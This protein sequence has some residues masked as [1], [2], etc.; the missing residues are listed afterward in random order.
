MK[1]ITMGLYSNL[2]G[3]YLMAGIFPKRAVLSTPKTQV[4]FQTAKRERFKPVLSTLPLQQVPGAPNGSYKTL[5]GAGL[6]NP[7]APYRSNWP[8]AEDLAYDTEYMKTVIESQ[9]VRIL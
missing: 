2:K 1:L 3:F 4:P 7:A 5:L 8:S 6:N 9:K